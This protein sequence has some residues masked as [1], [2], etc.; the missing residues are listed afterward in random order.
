MFY[1]FSILDLFPYILLYSSGIFFSLKKVKN[2]NAAY[3]LYLIML[4]FSSIRYGIGYDYYA[5]MQHIT[6]ELPEWRYERYEPLA[7]MLIRI[8]KMFDS[9]V[10][11]IFLYALLTLYPI[12]FVSKK[13]SAIPVVSML[14]Y[15]LYPLFYINSMSI[16]RNSLAF[17][18][19]FLSIYYLYNKNYIKYLFC[20]FV[21]TLFHA[22]APFAL[23]LLIIKMLPN[24]KKIYLVLIV[25]SYILGEFICNSTFL[26]SIPSFSVYAESAKEVGSLKYLMMILI[27]LNYYAWDKLKS[28]KFALY[29]LKIE[30]IGLSLFFLFII[31]DTLSM[32]ISSYFLYAMILLLP[33]QLYTFKVSVNLAKKMMVFFF[34]SLIAFQWFLVVGNFEKTGERMSVIPYQTIF[35]KVDYKNYVY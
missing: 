1:E 34:I 8:G 23:L 26:L 22:S 29:L 16:L 35:Y 25:I 24:N 14:I 15:L 3:L 27:V 5:Y 20:I 11:Y 12:Y 6:M 21:A 7:Y 18:I 33:L 17:S 30:S 31:D 2:I 10:L 13:C 9:Y 32:R 19:V 4:I 28:N